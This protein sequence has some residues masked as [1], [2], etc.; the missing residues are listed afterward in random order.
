MK[1]KFNI[2]GLLIGATS[3][4]LLL[5]CGG[6]DK[7]ANNFESYIQNY[8]NAFIGSSNESSNEKPKIYIDFSDGMASAFKKG[9]VNS[10]MIQKL[11]G[12]YLTSFEWHG[13]GNKYPEM[14]IIKQSDNLDSL[15]SLISVDKS[16]G[17]KN[18]QI[19]LAIKKITESNQDA[20]L[21]TDFELYRN[22]DI[23]EGLSY[24]MEDFIKWL[25]KG[26]SISFFYNKST[27]HDD[28]VQGTHLKEKHVFYTV[29]TKGR[30]TNNSIVSKI[31]IAFDGDP[32]IK[33]TY[34]RYDL[35][36][37]PYSIKTDYG[38]SDNSGIAN[39]P[40]I[41][42]GSK[43]IIHDDKLGFEAIEFPNS[44]EK[45]DGYFQK[46][47]IKNN[48]SFLSKLL[49]DASNND[50]FNLKSLK[51]IVTDVSDNFE[52]YSKYSEAKSLESEIKM[53]FDPKK[54]DSVW[55]EETNKNK[56]IKEL[57][58][59]NKRII[60]N[61]FKEIEGKEIVE[62]FDVNTTVF[63][64]DMAREAGKKIELQ[65]IF[66]K[67]YKK[68]KIKSESKPFIIRIDYVID[69]VDA[70]RSI[71][72]LEELYPQLKNSIIAMFDNGYKPKGV[73]YSYYLKF[74][75]VK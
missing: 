64:K 45:M 60:K 58:R 8:H 65:T 42:Q 46:N 26:N 49:L 41:I 16:Y 25:D 48:E 38:A 62:L 69:Q 17:D 29:F 18:A 40:T 67:N 43:M 44:W 34:N 3:L 5:S 55:S 36:G 63:E 70:N 57:Y 73:I 21:V 20:I 23:Q 7:L 27:F 2:L 13:L 56:K 52:K 4:S 51:V 39:I 68:E 15:Y 31:Q 37:N 61:E 30:A 1:F 53:V 33:G 74:P 47:L 66:N 19:D 54:R 35:S 9:S 71:S 12:S 24:A 11:A 28:K 6:E 72:K 14:E 59:E 50:A 22:G 32:L 10:T 75:S